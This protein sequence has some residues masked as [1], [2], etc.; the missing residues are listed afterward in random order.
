[1]ARTKY[2]PEMPH[3]R[4][5]REGVHHLRQYANKR[6]HS[7]AEMN[8]LFDLADAYGIDDLEFAKLLGYGLYGRKTISRYKP[9]P[10]SQWR[11]SIFN[12][13]DGAVNAFTAKELIDDPIFGFGEAMKE[14]RFV[15]LGP[16]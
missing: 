13:I 10:R 9:T 2:P 3:M 6:I 14:N 12:S 5:Y 11:Y 15:F 4:L 7:L 1:M 16:E 8:E